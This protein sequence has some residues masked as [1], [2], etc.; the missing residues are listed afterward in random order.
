MR[1]ENIRYGFLGLCILV[2]ILFIYVV[3]NSLPD[4]TITRYD[5]TEKIAISSLKDT[6]EL[7]GRSSRVL[8]AQ[9]GRIDQEL[10][11]RVML[12][13]GT[14]NRYY[15]L[16]AE[17]TDI[18]IIGPGEEPYI[19]VVWR[20]KE[21]GGKVQNVFLADTSL[22]GFSDTV[23]IIQSISLHVPEGTIDESFELDLTD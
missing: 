17:D 20:V 19:E 21:V 3:I 9:S 15:K 10:Y 23:G 4:F 1:E 6:S 18:Y 12:T 14:K 22:D 16:I 8:F 13:D 2:G 11:Y 7:H 5:V